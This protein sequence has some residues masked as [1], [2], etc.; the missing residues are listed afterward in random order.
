M[1]LLG[2]V[3]LSSGGLLIGVNKTNVVVVV[4]VLLIHL[5]CVDYYNKLMEVTNEEEKGA[6]K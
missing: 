2:P 3:G 5:I 6:T 4:V 1:V